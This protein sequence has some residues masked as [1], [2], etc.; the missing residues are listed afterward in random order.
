[1][2]EGKKGVKY[3][4]VIPCYNE[5]GNLSIL[6]NE[7]KKVMSSITDQNKYEII[8]VNDGSISFMSINLKPHSL[9]CGSSFRVLD[10]RKS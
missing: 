3:S 7:I 6:H 5:N 10:P 4:L 9:E 1:M 2:E 8:Y